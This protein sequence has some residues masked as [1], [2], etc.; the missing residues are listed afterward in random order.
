M[1]KK[2]GVV[3]SL[4][5]KGIGIVSEVVPKAEGAP[6]PAPQGS[7]S[8]FVFTLDQLSGFKGQRPSELGLAIGRM[9]EFDLDDRDR[10]SEI[11][12]KD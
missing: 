3:T 8:S 7:G 4:K 6:A 12:L 1:E 5:P 11:K 9:V 10:V 2:I